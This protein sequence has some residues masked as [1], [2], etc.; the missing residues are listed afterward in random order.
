MY[1]LGREH[2]NIAHAL[3]VDGHFLHFKFVDLITNL[4][5]LLHTEIPV[6]RFYLR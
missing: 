1:I 3:R 4:R 5:F 6:P 2:V